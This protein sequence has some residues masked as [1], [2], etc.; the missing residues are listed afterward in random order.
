MRRNG[1]NGR[2]AWMRSL[3]SFFWSESFGSPFLSPQKRKSKK[4]YFNFSGC[5]AIWIYWLL[6]LIIFLE[7]ETHLGHFVQEP[8]ALNF[9]KDS[10]L[11]GTDRFHNFHIIS[12]SP[13]IISHSESLQSFQPPKGQVAG[14]SRS[15][16]PWTI[17]CWFTWRVL[18]RDEDTQCF[19][20][21]KFINILMKKKGE[22][23][24][25][26]PESLYWWISEMQCFSCRRIGYLGGQWSHVCW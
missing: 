24:E 5:F 8:Q 26:A 20:L 11:K 19:N 12:W 18:S 1:M 21:G 25:K 15:N 22:T 7:P 10:L 4:A 23:S 2:V 9:G 6:K 14:S 3:P 17:K 13:W 16:F